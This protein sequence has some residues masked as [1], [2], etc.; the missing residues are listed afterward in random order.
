MNNAPLFSV[1]VTTHHRPALLERALRSLLAQSFPNFEIV[2]VADEGSVETKSVATA[3]L[4]PQDIFCVL[5]DAKGPGQSRNVGVD[6]ARG[7]YLLFLDDDDS[8]HS[9]Y[10][11][12]LVDCGKLS[13]EAVNYANFTE[14]RESRTEGGIQTISSREVDIGTTE[15]ALLLVRN[16]IPNNAVILPAAI[17]RQHKVDTNLQSHEDWDYLIAL[18]FQHT[19]NFIGIGGPVVHVN[20]GPSR[21]N[22]AKSSGSMVLDYLSIYRK[23]PLANDNIRNAR[24]ESLKNMGLDLPAALL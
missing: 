2:L 3:I 15:I 20:L 21:N 11:Q 24:K 16:F 8:Y 14:L 23:W 4:R 13:P 22:D 19:F 6:L 7:R 12:G 5:P 1:I 9:H 17:A 10:L 18:L